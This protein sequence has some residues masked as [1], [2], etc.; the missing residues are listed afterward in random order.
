LEG[1]F[2]P[3]IKPACYLCGHSRFHNRKGRVRDNAALKIVE[4]QACGLVALSSSDHIGTGHYEESG[5]H[6]DE[7][8]PIAAVLRNTAEDDQRRFDMLKRL[9][10]N[11]KVLDFG[12]GSAGFITRARSVAAQIAG[13]EPERRIHEHWGDEIVLYENLDAADNDYDL[14]TAFHVVEHLPDPRAILSDLAAHLGST[15]R[16]VVE[17]PSSDDALLTLYD[18]AAFQSFT[19]WSQ[20][21]FLFNAA[22]LH[23]LAIQSG[24][25]VV[26]IKQFQRYP[27]SNHMYWLSQSKPGGH[28]QWSFLDTPSLTE[29]YAASLGAL[30]KCDTLIAHLE[31]PSEASD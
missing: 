21:L 2:A 30:G 6:G 20:H 31:K 16:L 23:K 8:P 22:T 17:V 5:M 3:L 19:Y 25:R 14:I 11:H 4:C 10:V 18:C 26:S 28:Q 7:V 12:C 29:A 15:G 9:L 24:L 1:V 27:L 13:V